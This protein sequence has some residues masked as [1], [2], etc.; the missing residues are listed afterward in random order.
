MF[1]FWLIVILY[2]MLTLIL[3]YT[4]QFANIRGYWSEYLNISKEQ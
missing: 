3:I 2:S 4:Y 1:G